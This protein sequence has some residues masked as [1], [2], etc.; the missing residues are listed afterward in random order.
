V[1]R[2]STAPRTRRSAPI[3][4]PINH[5]PTRTRH[6]DP[7]SLNAGV[8]LAAV[9]V[10]E[11]EG[12]ERGTEAGAGG[13]WITWSAWRSS[14]CGMVSLRALAVLRLMTNS[15]LVGC[16]IGRSPALAPFKILST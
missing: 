12:F 16:S 15:N 1:A 9:L 13:Y 6:P 14:V 3:R 10:L 8:Q 2:T 7:I 4:V 11:D 5:R